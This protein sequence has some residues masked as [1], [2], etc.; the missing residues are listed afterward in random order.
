MAA[1]IIFYVV[2]I[3]GTLLAIMAYRYMDWICPF[4]GTSVIALCFWDR[5]ICSMS[6]KAH[7][8]TA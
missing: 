6:L 5:E 8:L 2:I 7:C 1:T 4:S 3:V